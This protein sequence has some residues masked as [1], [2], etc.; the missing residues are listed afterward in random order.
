MP[1]DG[2][3]QNCTNS[4]NIRGAL[5]ANQRVLKQRCTQTAP[6]LLPIDRQPPEQSDG[7][8]MPR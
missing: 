2:M 1:V 6:L 5:D 3:N 8:G 7:N 4:K